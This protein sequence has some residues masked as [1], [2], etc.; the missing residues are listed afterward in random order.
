MQG[1]L[2]LAQ[3]HLIYPYSASSTE[4]STQMTEVQF[5]TI[6]QIRTG[7]SRSQSS[8]TVVVCPSL[9]ESRTTALGPSRPPLFIG[10]AASVWCA[11]PGS[12]VSHHSPFP[13]LLS[14]PSKPA[15]S[16]APQLPTPNSI[17]SQDAGN[18]A[19]PDGTVREP[20]RLQGKAIPPKITEG[21][22]Q[23][24]GGKSGIYRSRGAASGRKGLT[25]CYRLLPQGK[26]DI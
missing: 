11:Y 8:A 22:S 16:P 2:Q 9:Q 4:K 26:L 5:R 25:H 1:G 13:R 10:G 19:H 3:L 7:S 17:P 6:S 23:D 21:R 20:D 15:G 14:Q 12:L 24:G 18:R